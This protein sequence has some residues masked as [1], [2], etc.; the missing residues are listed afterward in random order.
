MMMLTNK[1]WQSLRR[2]EEAESA[3]RAEQ[4]AAASTQVCL[5]WVLLPH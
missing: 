5:R 1:L 4:E 2:D 3:E